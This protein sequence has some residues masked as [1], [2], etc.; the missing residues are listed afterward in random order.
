[1]GSSRPLDFGHWAAH[2]LEQLTGHRLRHG[3]AVAI[4]IALDSTY[5][6]RWRPFSELDWRRIIDLLVAARLAICAPELAH[7]DADAGVLRGLDEF[8]EHLGGRLTSCCSGVI[9]VPF[10]AHEIDRRYDAEHRGLARTKRRSR[11]ASPAGESDSQTAWTADLP[12]SPRKTVVDEYFIENRTRLLDIAAFLDR[13]DRADPAYAATDFRMRAFTDA[14][15]A[16]P[17]DRPP[18]TVQLLF[19]D[20]TSEPLGTL[21]RKGAFGA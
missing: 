2:K 12:L 3:E 14:L 1:M 6:R 18:R 4:G 16:M 15:A 20:P 21:D 11:D 17:R 8:R 19:S 5:S 10:D 7:H 13:L 9:G